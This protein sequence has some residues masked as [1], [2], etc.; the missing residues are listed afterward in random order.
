MARAD[1]A[2]AAGPET[3]LDAHG[4][5]TPA[6]SQEAPAERAG[7]GTAPGGAATGGEELAKRTRDGLAQFSLDALLALYTEEVGRPAGST[8][9]GN[10]SGRSARPARAPPRL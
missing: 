4:G 6:E 8:H 5:A 10:S 2:P 9:P 3:P 7:A 1:T